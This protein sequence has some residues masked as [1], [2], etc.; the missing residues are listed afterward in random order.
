MYVNNKYFFFQI[1]RDACRVMDVG[2]F[3]GLFPKKVQPPPR[4]GR[5][6]CFSLEMGWNWKPN[7]QRIPSYSMSRHGDDKAFYS[8]TW[9]GRYWQ[10]VDWQ[11]L[12]YFGV[13]FDFKPSGG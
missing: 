6:F 4:H 1:G 5:Q 3:F 12:S 13:N 7:I 8:Q 9:T 2:I 10:I 11:W